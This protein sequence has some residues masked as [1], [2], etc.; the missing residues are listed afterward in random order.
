MVLRAALGICARLIAY[1]TAKVVQ[2]ERNSKKKPFFL[3]CRG[4]AYLRRQATECKPNTKAKFILI[5]LRRSLPWPPGSRAQYNVVVFN[6]YKNFRLISR[7]KG[8]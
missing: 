4:A 6:F 3:H 5:L 8:D 2:A 1:F 7:P